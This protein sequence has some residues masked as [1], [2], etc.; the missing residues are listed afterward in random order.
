MRVHI[1]KWGNS[2]ALRLPQPFAKQIHVRKNS[3]VDLSLE[4]G[5]LVLTP[6][7][8]RK[9]TLKEL[10]A[11]VTPENIHQEINTGSPRGREIW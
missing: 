8:S 9:Y 5:K 4:E 6:V 11:K 7:S 1:Q 2:L 10:L 3:M